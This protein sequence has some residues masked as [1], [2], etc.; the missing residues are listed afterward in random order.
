MPISGSLGDKTEVSDFLDD[1]D[2][3]PG[4]IQYKIISKASLNKNLFN[5]D[6]SFD[7]NK[8]EDDGD[9][10]VVEVLE[11]VAGLDTFRTENE[12]IRIKIF[13]DFFANLLTV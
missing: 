12:C 11:L 1:I 2:P 8:E 5:D 3:R 4:T 10:E 13:N 6:N 9:V 7:V